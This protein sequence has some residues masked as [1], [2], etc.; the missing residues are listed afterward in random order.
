TKKEASGNASVAQ[1]GFTVTS[2]A[3]NLFGANYEFKT[4]AT[5]STVTK[6]NDAT[7]LTV[8]ASDENSQVVAPGTTGSMTFTIAGTAEVK[9]TVAVEMR[10]I[11]DVVLEYKKG[12]TAGTYNPVKWTLKKGGNILVENSTLTAIAG[13]LNKAVYDETIDPGASYNNAGTYTIEWVWAF[14]SGNDALDTFLGTIANAPATTT[15]G[16]YTNQ[17]GTSTSINFT[18]NIS[19]T[20]VRGN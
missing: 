5:N 15:D 17:T 14:E 2:D 3:T 19:V 16:T 8:K 6:T 11:T 4:G 13:E 18:L 20:Q 10:D 12:E 9:A 7:K 1:W